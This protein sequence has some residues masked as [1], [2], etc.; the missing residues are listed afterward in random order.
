MCRPPA[1]CCMIEL[2]GLGQ[3]GA[4]ERCQGMLTIENH[5]GRLLELRFASPM[6]MADLDG[7]HGA[8]LRSMGTRNLVACT[9][10]LGAKVF[11]QAVSTRLVSLI[12]QENPRVDRNAILVGESAV[13]SMQTERIIREAGSPKRKAF[14]SSVELAEWLA[15]VL[16]A[17]EQAQLNVFLRETLRRH[18]E[19]D[20]G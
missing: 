20:Y 6:S 4:K 13:F 18:R 16:T 7:F 15:E 2:R 11:D 12:R 5:V 8:I 14:R 10:L 1:D 3:I 17:A 9:D 19:H